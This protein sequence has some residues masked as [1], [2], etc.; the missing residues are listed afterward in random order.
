[1][2]NGSDDIEF[3]S[4]LNPKRLTSLEEDFK[5]ERAQILADQKR[6]AKYGTNSAKLAALME[7]KQVM[8][9]SELVRVRDE[10]ARI[11]A[12]FQEAVKSEQSHSRTRAPHSKVK[13]PAIYT[14]EPADE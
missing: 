5:A 12:A 8:P 14:R 9:A 7:S 4:G 6:F 3:F 1:M 11:A 10:E 13:A 2:S